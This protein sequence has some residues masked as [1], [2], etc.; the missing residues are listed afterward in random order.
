MTLF[1]SVAVTVQGR[2]FFTG[3]LRKGTRGSPTRADRGTFPRRAECSATGLLAAS[4]LQLVATPRL[5]QVRVVAFPYSPVDLDRALARAA[6]QWADWRA[7]LREARC[8]YGHLAGRLGIRLFD[9]LMAADGLQ[10][11]SSGYALTDSGR[12]WR[13]E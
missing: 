12:A 13:T 3:S 2:R 8:C 4:A 7:R 10:P 6:G 5:R 1:S 9:G 11:A